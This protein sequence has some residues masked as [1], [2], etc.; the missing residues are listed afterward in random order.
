MVGVRT[1]NQGAA[2]HPVRG[3][4]A[5]PRGNFFRQKVYHLRISVVFGLLL[6]HSLYEVLEV[7]PD[8]GAAVIK[9]AGRLRLINRAYAVLADLLRTRHDG[10]SG[11]RPFPFGRFQ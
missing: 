4:I 5:S 11:L 2:Y 9:A 8:A 10:K 6:E 3:N 1:K 7:S